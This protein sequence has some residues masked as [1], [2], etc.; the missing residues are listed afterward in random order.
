MWLAALKVDDFVPP[1]LPAGDVPKQIHLD[2]GVTELEPA[3]A[4]AVRLGA[5]IAEQIPPEARQPGS[6]QSA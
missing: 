3:V 4:E 6:D 5:R 1:T 2:L